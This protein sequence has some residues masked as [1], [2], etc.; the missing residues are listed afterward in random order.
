M[1]DG[2]QSR[3]RRLGDALSQF[4]NVLIFNGEANHSISGDAYRFNRVWLI[5]ILDLLFSPLEKEHCKN[6]HL[7]DI[8]LACE[9]CSLSRG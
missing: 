9:L 5:K 2:Q 4:F 6:A 7:K 3:L 1:Q 8:R